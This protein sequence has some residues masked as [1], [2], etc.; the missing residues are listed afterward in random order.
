MANTIDTLVSKALSVLEELGAG[1]LQSDEDTKLVKDA[2]T[3]L[4]ASLITT[5]VLPQDFDSTAIDDATFLP[6]ARLLANA[7][8]DDFGR[9]YSEDVR[10]IQEAQLR[11]VT[12]SGPIY[13]TLAADYF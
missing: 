3:P 7:V 6:L 9:P 2:A 10:V 5:T 12:A 13:S 8:G 1:Q 11:R 4:I